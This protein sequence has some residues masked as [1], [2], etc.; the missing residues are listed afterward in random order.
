MLVDSVRFRLTPETV[1][2]VSVSFK[3]AMPIESM[4]PRRTWQR[5][6]TGVRVR[7]LLGDVRSPMKTRPLT[8]F[9]HLARA[10]EDVKPSLP[11]DDYGLVVVTLRLT[12]SW[13]VRCFTAAH[14]F[15]QHRGKRTTRAVFW[16]RALGTVAVGLVL[17]AATTADVPAARIKLIPNAD[18]RITRLEKF[19]RYYHCTTPYPTSDYLR[20]ADHYGLDYRLLPAISIRE[21]ACGV[22]QQRE[23][24]HWGYHADQQSFPSVAD[25][26]DFMSRRLTEH[27]FYRG[28]TL[29]AKLFTYNPRAAYPE[30]VRRIMRQIDDSEK[31][32]E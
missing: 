19:F 1:E 27:P 24:N 20:A 21:T 25:G 11:P 22:G 29:Q 9:S 2:D 6:R 17:S 5:L 16:A 4:S 30:E 7:I 8:I 14:N 31:H 12:P 28:K 32:G 23:N 18:P 10:V 3:Y 26:I 13:A 15:L